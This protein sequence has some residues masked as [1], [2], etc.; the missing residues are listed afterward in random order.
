LVGFC[1]F[2]N[3]AFWRFGWIL[4]TVD[5]RYKHLPN[6]STGFLSPSVVL[7]TGVYCIWKFNMSRKFWCVCKFK[8]ILV[9]KDIWIALRFIK[10][11][12]HSFWVS[13]FAQKLSLK[14]LYW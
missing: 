10:K 6:I 3:L 8:M 9:H 5:S 4:C 7:I 12:T 14:D 13:F 11:I 2:G 1:A